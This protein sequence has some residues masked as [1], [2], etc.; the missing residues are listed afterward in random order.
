MNC[1]AYSIPRQRKL[2]ARGQAAE[3]TSYL[4]FFIFLHFSHLLL[5]SSIFSGFSLHSANV[6]HYSTPAAVLRA[7]I[8]DFWVIKVNVQYKSSMTYQ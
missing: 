1:L 3:P 6:W 7:E 2:A 4:F 8:T 5:P